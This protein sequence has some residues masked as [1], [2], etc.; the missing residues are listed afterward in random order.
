MMELVIRFQ[1]AILCFNNHKKGSFLK[2]LWRNQE[3]MGQYHFLFSNSDFFPVYHSGTNVMNGIIFL[4]FT[5]FLV[6]L[7]LFLRRV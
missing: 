1:E 5:L 7:D 6:T 4:T 3:N 2:W